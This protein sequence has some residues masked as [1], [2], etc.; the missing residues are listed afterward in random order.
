MLPETPASFTYNNQA[1]QWADHMANPPVDGK[2]I[3][4]GGP[5]PDKPVI[6]LAPAKS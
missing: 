5:W 4:P 1:S 6:P 3:D 2:S